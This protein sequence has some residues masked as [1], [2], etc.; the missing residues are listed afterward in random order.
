MMVV[1][2][3][4]GH[5]FGSMALIADGWHMSTHAAAM[6]I[7]VLA[8]RYARKNANNRQFTFGTGKVG[9][10]EEHYQ[11]ARLG[12]RFEATVLAGPKKGSLDEMCNNFL[13]WMKSQVAAGNLSQLTL[14][15]RRT[16]LRQARDCLSPKGIRIYPAWQPSKKGAKPVRVPLSGEF[17]REMQG[18]VTPDRPFLLTEYGTPFIWQPRHTSKEMDHKRWVV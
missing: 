2:I 10:L 15:S 11:R 13:L 6:L 3:T 5:V 12:D 9:D 1:E 8:Y 4:A 17:V 14:N 7:A 18:A 16:G